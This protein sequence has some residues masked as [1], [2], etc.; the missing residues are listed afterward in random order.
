VDRISTITGL[1]NYAITAIPE[2]LA[3]IRTTRVIIALSTANHAFTTIAWTL[4]IAMCATLPSP[5]TT[6]LYCA[7]LHA[8]RISSLTGPHTNVVLVAVVSI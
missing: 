6:I 7:V 3:I 8:V 2:C 5:K 1:Q 4:S